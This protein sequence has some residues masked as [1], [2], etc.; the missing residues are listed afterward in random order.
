MNLTIS[1]AAIYMLV[2]TLVLQGFAEIWFVDARNN[3]TV[4]QNVI[5]NVFELA[6]LAHIFNCRS[7]YAEI[8]LF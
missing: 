5:F 7:H 4:R 3:I 2:V 6:V 1:L 8:D